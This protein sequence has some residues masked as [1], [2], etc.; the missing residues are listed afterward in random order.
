MVITHIALSLGGC[1]E[2]FSHGGGDTTGQTGGLD[3][4]SVQLYNFTTAQ[5]Y[6][7][8]TVER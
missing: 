1:L 6:K 3:C 8:I 4:T 5:L 2:D 7:C